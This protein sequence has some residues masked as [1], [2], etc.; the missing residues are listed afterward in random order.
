MYVY[1]CIYMICQ[2]CQV[3]NILINIIISSFEV[4][5]LFGNKIP[6]SA[7]PVMI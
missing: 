2:I 1:A 3:S 6:V 4:L 5:R 7:K